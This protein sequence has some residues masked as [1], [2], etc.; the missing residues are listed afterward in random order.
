L[1]KHQLLQKYDLESVDCLIILGSS[2]TSLPHLAANI[3]NQKL[4]KKIMLVGGIGHS[5]HYLYDNILM[6]PYL[7]GVPTNNRAEADIYKDI[8]VQYYHIEEQNILVE[9][10]STNCGSNAKEALHLLHNAGINASSFILMQD[11]TMQL[12]T[13]ASFLHEW[14]DEQALLINYSP[15]IPQ[16]ILQDDTPLITDIDEKAWDID[17]FVSLLL[18]EIPRL[19]DT[20]LGYGPQGKNFIAHVHIPDEI[21]EC[22]RLL[23]NDL[24]DFLKKRL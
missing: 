17:R 9:N 6:H 11:P 4:V 3:F 20:S 14:H 10:Q 5:T 2:L 15:Y 12:R 8:L 7:K 21:L 19:H 16:I 18:G 13:Y 23:L 22:H 24:Q 1:D